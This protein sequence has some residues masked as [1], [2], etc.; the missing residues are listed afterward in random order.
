MTANVGHGLELLLLGELLGLRLLLLHFEALRRRLE[1]LLVHHEEVAG[2]PLR[3][4]GLCEDVLH[5]RNRTDLALIVDVLE[6][7]HLVRLVNDPI[8]LLEVDQFVILA[9]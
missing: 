4:V 1:L 8:A 9:A 5:S 6:L 3:E 7:V 2:A